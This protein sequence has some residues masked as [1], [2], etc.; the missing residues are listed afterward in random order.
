MDIERVVDEEALWEA[1]WAAVLARDAGADGAFVTCVRSTGIYCRPSC[2]AR[3]PRRENVAF[4]PSAAAAEAAGFRACKRCRPDGTSPAAL[5][6]RAIAAACRAIDAAEDAP[7]FDAL[8][9]EAGLSR[10]A[11]QRAFRAVTGLTPGAYAAAARA[12]RARAALRGEGS[13]TEAIYAAGFAS[14]GRFYEKAPAM[15]G[16]TPSRYRAGGADVRIAF[17]IARSALGLVLVAGTLTGVAALALGDDEAAL[18]AEL[19]ARFPKAE[20]IA[21]D[22]AFAAWVRAVLAYVEAPRVGLDLPLDIRGTAFQRRVWQALREI[23]RGRT[24]SYAEIAARIGDPK[25]V[26]AVAGACAANAIAIAIPCHRVVRSDGGL[27]GYRWGTARKRAL[28]E[29]ERTDAE[30]PDAEHEDG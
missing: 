10:F 8:A 15:L 3:H 9:A 7:D 16:M 29:R 1:R 25:A 27:S 20:L 19:R 21:G 12:G 13:V 24:A 26:R 22:A 28:L 17:A 2:P 23:P 18:L 30:S 6:T 4:L 5:R 11:F 14:S